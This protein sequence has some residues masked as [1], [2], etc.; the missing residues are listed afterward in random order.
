M[1]CRLLLFITGAVD[2]RLTASCN[3]V[4]VFNSLTEF[5]LVNSSNDLGL[6]GHVTSQG[7]PTITWRLANR[8]ASIATESRGRRHQ[9]GDRRTRGISILPPW[10]T[11]PPNVC[12]SGQQA[13]SAA[14]AWTSST[15][16][17]VD[18]ATKK[19]NHRSPEVTYLSALSSGE[20]EN[21]VTLGPA[22]E[23]MTC[24]GGWTH[25]SP[26]TCTGT[27]LLSVSLM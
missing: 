25:G 5:V 26:S 12:P 6:L 23:M 3:L 11:D 24:P 15:S 16:G 13:T 7:P 10:T 14:S 20:Q 22:A 27:A 2:Q 1:S 8:N 9:C 4:P 21:N 18:M 19:V 17:P